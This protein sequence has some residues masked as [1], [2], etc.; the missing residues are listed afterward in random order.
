MP[1]KTIQ[2]KLVK[3]PIGYEK[4]QRATLR[5]LG[6][7]KLHQT[8][9]KQDTPPIRGMIKAVSHLVTVEASE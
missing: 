8:V 1:P 2:I 5:A 4:S 7:R 6:L 9:E 3:S